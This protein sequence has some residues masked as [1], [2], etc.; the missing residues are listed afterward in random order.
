MYVLVVVFGFV[1]GWIMSRKAAVCGEGCILF[2][3]SF[4]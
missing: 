4:H 2:A 3:A 1:G